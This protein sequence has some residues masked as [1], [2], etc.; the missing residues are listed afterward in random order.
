MQPLSLQLQ[1]EGN[2]LNIPLYTNVSGLPPN[3]VQSG[4]PNS[5]SPHL[6]TC[7]RGPT[8]GPESPVSLFHQ[9]AV[10]ISESPDGQAEGWLNRGPSADWWPRS[11]ERRGHPKNFSSENIKNRPGF[12]YGNIFYAPS[13]E[14]K[15]NNTNYEHQIFFKIPTHKC[16]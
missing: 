3:T 6:E 4:P 15:V 8:Q 7:G 14:L 2:K 9:G 1:I 16:S 12:Q 11:P 5:S 10:R 13:E